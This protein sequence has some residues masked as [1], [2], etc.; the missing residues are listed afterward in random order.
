MIKEMNKEV[1]DQANLNDDDEAA[2]AG[3][4]QDDKEE[5]AMNEKV[6]EIL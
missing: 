2:E 1:N 4:N 6:K 5:A 3:F